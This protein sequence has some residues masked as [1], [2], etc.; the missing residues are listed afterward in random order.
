MHLLKELLVEID[1]AF[2][3]FW[4]GN[5]VCFWTWKT[6]TFGSG[7]LESETFSSGNSGLETFAPGLGKPKRSD[8]DI[9]IE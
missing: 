8:L 4:L 3:R 2:F 7:D 5:L 9:R 6:K 1:Q